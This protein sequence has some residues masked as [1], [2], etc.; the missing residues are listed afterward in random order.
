M[1]FHPSR[2]AR[3]AAVIPA[4]VPP[5]THTSQNSMVSIFWGDSVIFVHFPLGEVERLDK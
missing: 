1:T 2:A 5:A 3:T 4:G